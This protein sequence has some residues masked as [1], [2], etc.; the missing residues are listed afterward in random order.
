M[1]SVAAGAEE[2]IKELIVEQGLG[3]GDPLPT[4]TELME[5]FG[6]SRN[7]LRE[8]LKSLQAMRIVEIRRGFGTY[9]GT[10]SLEP[11]IEAMAFRTVVGH[12]QGRGSLLEL[13]QM[14]EALEA[15]LM[16]RLAGRL[17]E[18]DLAELD[19]LV[20]RMHTEVREE[21][22]IA[23]RTDRA[24]H[25]ALHRSL[26]NELLSELLDAFW[27]AFHRVRAQG[28][29]TAADGEEL[30]RMH[31]RI[32][33]AVRAGDAEAAEAAVHRHFDDIRG[34]LSRH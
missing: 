1:R 32:V 4:E 31:A 5:R 26:G 23:A 3:P 16:H 11:L 8:A 12:R 14:R 30:A 10:M 20:A 33:E 21:G 15:G 25:R 27:S 9:V 13:L 19:A 2:K 24:F 34:R 17:P 7:S 6:V 28:L 18:E 22:E 29:G